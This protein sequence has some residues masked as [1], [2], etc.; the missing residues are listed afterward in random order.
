M[1]GL[2][3]Q[4]NSGGNIR[5][6]RAMALGGLLTSLFFAGVFNF[7]LVNVQELI[8]DRLVVIVYCGIVFLY[9]FKKKLQQRKY[10]HFMY[11]GF[12]LYM[13]QSL[14]ACWYNDFNGA[15]FPIFILINL[16]CIYAFRKDSEAIIFSLF[17]SSAAI[18]LIIFSSTI[19]ANDKWVF[20]AT[21]ITSNALSVFT[22][23]IKNKFMSEMK[24]N[25][26][27]LKSL[28]TRTE[29]GM[30]VTDTT[31]LI[32]D[33]NQRAIELFGYTKDEMLDVDFRVLRKNP[34]TQEEIED[35]FLKLNEEHF[36]TQETVLTRKDG[37]E[38]FA[39][40]SIIQLSSQNSKFLVYRVQDISKLKMYQEE[41]VLEKEKAE[42]AAKAKSNFLAIMSHEIRTPLNGVIATSSLL[43][44]SPLNAEQNDQLDTI[45]RSGQNLL[46]LINDILE[47][48]KMENGK[49]ELDPRPSNI[50]L[51]LF[52]VS[53]LLRAS[54]EQKGIQ[55]EVKIAQKIPTSLVI[56]DHRLKQILINL[57]GNAIKFTS[58][59]KVTIECLVEKTIKDRHLIQFKISDTGIGI[60][61][62]KLPLLFQS[63]TQVDA[64][65]SRKYG[66]TGL[67]LT[68]SKQL[69]ELMEGE[70]TVESVINKG[71]C[72]S[73][74]IWCNEK[75]MTDATALMDEVESDFSH[76]HVLIA[77]D[78]KINIQVFKFILDRININADF[79]EN[80]LEAL[81][82]HQKKSYDLI[83]MDM[84]MPELDGLE[85]TKQIRAEG[86]HQ[87][88]I[89]AISA[90][91]Y[92]EDRKLCID[93][94]MNDFMPKPF[95]LDKVKAMLNSHFKSNKT[96]KPAA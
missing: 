70:I 85:S 88:I 65:I 66:G 34:L 90:N 12:Y 5:F 30:F 55:L 23:R 44:Q 69:V 17:G 64:G 19:S 93:A 29:N 36:W 89:I 38:F 8:F 48:S 52:D 27:I 47:F 74:S 81:Q 1:Y 14:F 41:L 54:A 96:S 16:I 50:Q 95:E 7:I 6:Y 24:L 61:E 83:F 20:V 56:D 86:G 73:F 80:G 33:L 51:A 63:F 62:E 92:P 21:V 57:T 46:M 31:G 9:G 71:T 67:G 58:H 60:P 91:A 2:I 4:V 82:A 3:S 25:Q 40:I 84:Q 42:Q 35:G 18:L 37:Q 75:A 72:F 76:L 79:A 10:S 43:K 53:S 49:L 13:C 59:G 78:N 15:Y 94:G 45:Y 22:A 68:I 87:P 39:R 28:I 77:E 26:K 11:T 32:F